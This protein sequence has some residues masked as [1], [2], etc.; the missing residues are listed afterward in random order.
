M[1]VGDTDDGSGLHHMVY[2]LIYNA[3]DKALAG[4]ASLV[5]VTLNFD[6]SCTVA[7]NGR[8]L[9]TDIDPHAGLSTAEMIMTR[10]PCGNPYKVPEYP[11]GVGVAM[12]NALSS[13]L[14]LRIWRGGQEYMMR[15]ADGAVDAP[16]RVVAPSHDRQGTEI[17]FLPSPRIFSR[18]VFDHVVLEPRLSELAALPAGPRIVL[19]DRRGSTPRST[20][21]P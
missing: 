2:E 10:L 16:L 7:D 20:Q 14:T 21:L 15:F 1:F 19:T 3:M 6:G 17:T 11:Q 4:P 5:V 8:G 9:S 18:T 12:V 13:R